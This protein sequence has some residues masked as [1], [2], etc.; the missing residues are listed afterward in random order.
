MQCLRLSVAL[1]VG[2]L[3]SV[4]VSHA[5]STGTVTATCKDGTSFTG[6][7]RSGACRGH[8]GVQAWGA[9]TESS[10]LVNPA[11]DPNPASSRSPA[12]T[13]ASATGIIAATCKDGTSFTGAKRSGACRGHGGVQSWGAREATTIPMSAPAQGTPPASTSRRAASPPAGDGQ[14]WVNTDSHVYHCPGRRWYGKTKQGSY[15][16]E[17]QAQ[18][19][20]A[21]PDHGKACG[22]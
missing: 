13:Q 5:Q 8:G 10:G 7:K 11:I 12:Q 6:A 22:S 1:L 16:S 19:Q 14:V 9:A 4:G 3:F 2:L 18:A 15:M 17:S 21:K 20:G